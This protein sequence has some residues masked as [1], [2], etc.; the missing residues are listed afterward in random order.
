MKLP[1][2]LV[3]TLLGLQIALLHASLRLDSATDD[4]A[5]HDLRIHL[6][7]L[8]SLLAPLRRVADLPPLYNAAAELGALTAPVRELEVLAAELQQRGYSAAAA[9]RQAQLPA[10]YARVLQSAELQHLFT[11]L[12][13]WPA[14]LRDAQR[15]SQLRGLQGLVRKR[16]HKQVARLAVAL[17]TPGYD[18]HRLRLLIKRVR[19]A[20][21]AYPTLI[22]LSAK[23][24][25]RLKL[26]QSA[27]GDW[28]D[29]FQWCARLEQEA[30][31]A[32]LRQPWQHCAE[33]ALVEA[34]RQLQR[35]AKQ[36]QREPLARPH[37]HPAAA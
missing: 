15:Q 17:A 31:L 7:R 18:R 12:D 20:G 29:H 14:E 11:L 37:L 21:E 19:Y 25:A 9:A 5:L 34:E 26:A 23:T 8:R 36:L 10:R 35:L 33:Q 4:E 32:P 24:L 6:Q 3:A 27:L 1:D 2:S 22:G 13:G 16:L 30:D 28:H